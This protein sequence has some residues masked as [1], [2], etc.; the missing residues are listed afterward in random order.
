MRQTE[1]FYRK[2]LISCG[3]I[4]SSND[5]KTKPGI[6]IIKGTTLSLKK[7][8]KGQNLKKPKKKF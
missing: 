3:F 8:L 7:T 5:S 4:T 1:K 2:F 6:D